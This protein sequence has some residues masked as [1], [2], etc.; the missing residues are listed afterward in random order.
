MRR[1]RKWWKNRV[2]DAKHLD[3]SQ[4]KNMELLGRPASNCF[5]ICLIIAWEVVGKL[6]PNIS[7]RLN[8]YWLVYKVL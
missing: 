5:L 7:E 2:R 6:P 8:E 4:T 3:V 1:K